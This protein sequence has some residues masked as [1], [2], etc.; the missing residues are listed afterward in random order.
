ML[1]SGLHCVFKLRQLCALTCCRV[2]CIVFSWQL[3]PVHIEECLHCVLRAALATCMLQ[4]GLHCVLKAALGRER[5]TFCCQ[6]QLCHLYVTEWH[7]LCSQEAHVAE[8]PAFCSQRQLWLLV[9]YRVA[10]M[11]CVLRKLWPVHMTEW[12]AFCSQSSSGPHV[13]ESAL[14]DKSGSAETRSV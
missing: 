11:Y 4:C 8:W 2:A 10:C 6:R 5:P 3:Q 12:P 1:Q 13:V 9:C 7:V 14:S